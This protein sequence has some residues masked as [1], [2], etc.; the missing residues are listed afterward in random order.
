MRGDRKLSEH[1][2]QFCFLGEDKTEVKIEPPVK[3]LASNKKETIVAPM[4]MMLKNDVNFD[5]STGKFCSL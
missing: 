1:P 2:F 5:Y 4:A 3:K